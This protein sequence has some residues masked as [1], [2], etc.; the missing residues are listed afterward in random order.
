MTHLT[1]AIILISLI[2]HR[3]YGCLPDTKQD[4]CN[5]VRSDPHQLERIIPSLRITGLRFNMTDMIEFCNSDS[6]GNGQNGLC[7]NI[8]EL[9]PLLPTSLA[10]NLTQFCNPDSQIS[11]RYFNGRQVQVVS[12]QPNMGMESRGV[13]TIWHVC[14]IL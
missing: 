1:L 6:V 7:E 2:L 12:I 9:T 11:R 8:Q 4:Y 10:S 13:H 14:T 5:I 3:A